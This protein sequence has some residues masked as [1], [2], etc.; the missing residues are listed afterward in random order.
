MGHSLDQTD[1]EEELVPAGTIDI[2]SPGDVSGIGLR[3]LLNSPG[4]RISSGPA[5]R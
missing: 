4:W 2:V 5:I 1:D 3:A